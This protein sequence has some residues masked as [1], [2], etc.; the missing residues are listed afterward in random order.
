M[1]PSRPARARRYLRGIFRESGLL[2]GTPSH[3]TAGSG[4]PEETLF[5]AVL[6]TLTRV[7][8]DEG[9]LV[10]ILTEP[11]NA[12]VRQYKKLFEMEGSEL[13]FTEGALRAIAQL[14]KLKDTGARGLRS[15]I[16]DI[17]NDAMFDLPDLEPKGKYIVSEDVVNRKRSL[18]DLKPKLPEKMS[19]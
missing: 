19:A 2:Y 12:L 14:A 5:L 4:A 15:I 18:F 6:R 13:E 17:M 11:R 16:E 1:L 7:A 9:S 10:R 3:A 8:L